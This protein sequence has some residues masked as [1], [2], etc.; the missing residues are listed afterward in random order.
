MR[1][2]LV[3][4][5]VGALLAMP[6]LAAA[7]PQLPPHFQDEVV[8]DGIE[9]PVN[10]R[11][12]PDGRVFVAT[13][14]GQ[15]LVYDSVNDSTPTVFADLRADVYDRGDRGLLGLEL[16]PKFEEGGHAYVYALYTWDHVLGEA[17]DPAHPKYGKP[18]VSGDP[19]CPSQNSSGSCLVSGRLVRLQESFLNPNHAVEVEGGLPKEKELLQGW[20]QQFDS[21]SVG[22]LRFGDEGAL[23][24]SG[25]DGAS[26]ESIPDYG[27]LG[28]PP[29]PCGDAPTPAGTAPSE[30]QRHEAHGGAL[31]SQNLALLSGAILRVDPDTGDAFS[32][33]PLLGN[34][35]A[36]AERTVAKGFRNPFR[37]TFDPQTGEIYSGNVGSS[38]IEEIDRFQ[39]PPT[40]LYNSGW[41]CY[42]GIQH[43]FQFKNLGLDTCKA[44]YQAEANGEP[45]TSEPFFTY[46]HKQTVV[47][48]DECPTESGSALSGLSFYEGGRYPSRYEGALFFADAVRGCMWVMYP[49]AD[50]RPDPSTTERFLRESNIYPGVKIA[51]GPDGYLYYAD[52]LGDNFGEGSIHRIGF[53]ENVPTARLEA[54][55][56][57]GLYDSSGDF[58]T[59]LDAS[60]SSDPN[61]SAASLT[62]EWDLDE[63]GDFESSGSAKTKTVTFTEAEQAARE[64][65]DPK[66]SANRVV[67]VRVKDADGSTSLARVTVYPGDKPPTVTITSPLATE[68]WSV[69]D[70]IDLNAKAL[71]VKGAEINSPL[72]Y[73]WV[74]RMAHCPD[75]AHPNAC[76]VHPLQTFAGIKHAEFTAPQHEYPSYIQIVLRVS[77][78]RGLSG[79]ASL[80]LQPQTVDVSLQSVPA[81]VP[82]LAGS[83]ETATPFSA[84]A[85]E[86][87][88]IQLSAPATYESNGI[89]YEFEEWSDGGA[90]SHSVLIAG[91]APEYKAFYKEVPKPIEVRLASEPPGIK[92]Q[93]GSTE[94]P[95]PFAVPALEGSEIQ[96][97]APATAE[98]NGKRYEFERWSDNGAIS[99]WIL[100]AEGE[101]EHKALYKEVAAEPPKEE[102]PTGGGGGGGGGTGTGGSTGG[103]GTGGGGDTGGGGGASNPANTLL[104]KHPPAS[105]GST[106][107]KFT[108]S[109]SVDGATFSCKLDGKPKA[110]CRSPKAYEKLKPGKHA[111]KVWASAGVLTDPTPAKFSWKVLPP[112]KR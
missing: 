26:Y 94:E 56:P 60:K 75:P 33:N 86:G 58:E 57:Y 99:H 18:G 48:E 22:E 54:E 105:T 108:F 93:A 55:P 73:Y 66:Q 53:S 68:K 32:G 35:N 102:P 81:G 20:C 67:A 6:S 51:E 70:T 61:Q 83:T 27:Q 98:V 28:T 107:A 36:N 104:G 40:T 45:K 24:V 7:E 100:V 96:L 13:K 9:Q 69:G 46:S 2:A 80:N 15:I 77:D 19:G 87:S 30:A 89:E 52:L 25:G 78:K 95:T 17:W 91:G 39:A 97:T 4:A 63:D 110:A 42:E 41:P 1:I 50:G 31:R 44:L 112:T 21:H 76:H 38:E 5:A 71:D 92:L 37:Y 111:F 14:P 10:F 12:A 65:T 101:P 90:I 49:G 11:F 3:A 16:D 29:N 82:L 23:Y 88:E 43:Q 106:V 85:I 79:T 109:A 8:F 72:P 59:T 47:P 64:S 84:P 34:G 62:Y 103:G 74:T